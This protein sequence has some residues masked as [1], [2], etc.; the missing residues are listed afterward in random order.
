MSGDVDEELDVGTHEVKRRPVAEVRLGRDRIVAYVEPTACG[1]LATGS[2]AGV[3]GLTTGWPDDEAEDEGGDGAGAEG[4]GDGS[5]ELPGGPYSLGS[6]SHGEYGAPFAQ[7]SCGKRAMVI[8][9]DPKEHRRVSGTRGAVSVVRARD[10]R[11]V[12]VVVGPR[13]TRAGIAEALASR[14][15]P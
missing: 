2:K 3:S 9:Y 14:R 5:P 7:L 4:E 10:G 1:L 12:Y 6:F 11:T 15:T 13:H 8:E